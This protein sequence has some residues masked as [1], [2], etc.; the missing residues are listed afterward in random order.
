MLVGGAKDA[1]ES[2]SVVTFRVDCSK[3][4]LEEVV[5]AI[6]LEM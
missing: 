4:D 6:M 3:H 2:Y 5:N 1:S